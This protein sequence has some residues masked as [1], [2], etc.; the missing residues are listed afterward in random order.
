MTYRNTTSSI[1]SE[2]LLD[3]ATGAAVEPVALAVA[4]VIDL[5]PAAAQAYQRLNCLGG[6]LLDSIEPAFGSGD[7]LKTIFSRLAEIQPDIAPL[8]II[9]AATSPVPTPLHTYIGHSFDGLEWNHL[10][11]G[12]DE[13]V[14]KTS[15]IGYRTSLLRIA[16]GK[17]MPHHGHAGEELTVV[18]EGSYDS[19]GSRF[20][21]GDM[22][23]ANPDIKHKPVADAVHGCLCLA[24]LSAPV[25]LTGFVGWFINPFLKV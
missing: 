7:D 16:P 24:V 22:E 25:Q 20:E 14:I 21:T 17:A 23:V 5:N 4:T 3:Y 2:L 9:P 10:T 11:S 6:E 19:Q 15:Q 12:V 1:P 8:C 18:I 13:H